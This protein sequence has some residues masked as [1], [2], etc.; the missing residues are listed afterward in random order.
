MSKSLSILDDLMRGIKHTNQSISDKYRT[1]KGQARIYEWIKL[2][3]PI[4]ITKVKS[5]KGFWYNEY[6]M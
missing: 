5:P 4:I 3:Y 2:E 1:T 6:S